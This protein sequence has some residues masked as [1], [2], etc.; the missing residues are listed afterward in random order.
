MWIEGIV[1]E[2]LLYG[3]V[4]LGVFISFRIMDFP[5][6]TV[7]G[8]FPFGAAVMAAGLVAGLPAPV[9]LLLATVAG[10]LA[11]CI[12]AALH[13]YLKIPNL[14][15][16]I[17]TMGALWSVNLRVMGN[18]ANLGIGGPNYETLLESFQSLVSPWFAVLPKDVAGPVMYLAFFLIA[19]LL[20]MFLL[21]L[22][23]RTDLGMTIGAMGN[24]QQMVISNG[25]DPRVLKFIGLGLSN[26]MVAMAGALAA[27]VNGFADANMG[28]GI[29][30]AGLASVMIG[31][32]LFRSNRIWVLT[33][34]VILGSIL[35][36]GLMFAGRSY[37]YHIGLNPN[38]LK[39]ITTVLVVLAIIISYVNKTNARANKTP[40]RKG[41]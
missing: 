19:V 1:V 7:D 2:G 22:F 25:S 29:I 20:I 30:I 40:V 10:V 24:N 4:A 38:D 27:Q 33:L 31:E 34:R 26:G 17:L 36:R 15:A 6:M 18:K 32:L 3:I 21:N 37:G 23:F 5:D 8:S 9:A 41:A 13:N 16:G 28:Q 14:L 35:Y 12:T 11:G 39:L